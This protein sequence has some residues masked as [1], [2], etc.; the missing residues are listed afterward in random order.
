MV[1]T[2][3]IYVYLENFIADIFWDYIINGLMK[4][5]PKDTFLGGVFN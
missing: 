2:G 5:L 3:C 1:H 4:Q